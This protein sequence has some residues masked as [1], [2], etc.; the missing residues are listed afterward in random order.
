[1]TATH[2]FNRQLG[3]CSRRCPTSF[4]PGVVAFVDFNSPGRTPRLVQKFPGV[5]EIDR[6][7]NVD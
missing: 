7:K 3:N 2:E 5:V 6:M 4:I 1:M